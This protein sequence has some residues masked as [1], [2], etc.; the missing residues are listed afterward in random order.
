MAFKI[1]KTTKHRGDMGSLIVFRKAYAPVKTKKD[2]AEAI[3]KAKKLVHRGENVNLILYY[4][5]DKKNK[6]RTVKI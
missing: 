5:L 6:L 1:T 4:R 3:R 2:E